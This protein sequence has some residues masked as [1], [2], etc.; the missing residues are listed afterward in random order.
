MYGWGD[1]MRTFALSVLVL[2]LC[3]TLLPGQGKQNKAGF[4]AVVESRFG[5][6]DTNRNGSLESA[7][8]DHLLKSH[9]VRGDE[10]AAVASIHVWFRG[11]PSVQFTPP[12]PIMR[13]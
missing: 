5:N 10:A 11:N 4:V 9:S 6:W 12:I 13:S 7:E 2:G 8:I 3:G 1:S